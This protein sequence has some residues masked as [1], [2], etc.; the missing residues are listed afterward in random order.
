MVESECPQNEGSQN[1][2]THI[3]RIKI[4]T[5]SQTFLKINLQKIGN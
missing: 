4:V 2:W 5:V 1:Y 3:I